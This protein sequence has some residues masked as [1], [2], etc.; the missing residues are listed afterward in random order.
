MPPN[1]YLWHTRSFNF[2]DQWIQN[3]KNYMCFSVALDE[4]CSI[5]DTAK[6]YFGYICLKGLINYK[7]IMSI[8]SLK[9]KFMGQA[10]FNLLHL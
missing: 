5:S 2:K 1:S 9:I 8:S 3:L 4:L 7:E 10:F 6:Y